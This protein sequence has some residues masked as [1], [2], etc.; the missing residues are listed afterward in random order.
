MQNDLIAV[1]SRKVLLHVGTRIAAKRIKAAV[2]V[3]INDDRHCGCV[4]HQGGRAMVVGVDPAEQD[5]K[6]GSLIAV[7]AVPCSNHA[8]HMGANERCGLR[9]GPESEDEGCQAEGT[10]PFG[11][12]LMRSQVLYRAVRQVSGSQNWCNF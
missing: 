8:E 3:D 7:G 2:C 10:T 5:R 4:S 6:Y 12:N 11:V 1:I 9:P